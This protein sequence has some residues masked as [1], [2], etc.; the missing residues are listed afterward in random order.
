MII[1]NRS[2]VFWVVTAGLRKAIM[3]VT[4]TQSLSNQ[5]R[6][7]QLLTQAPFNGAVEAKRSTVS[8][9]AYDRLGALFP[10]V[11]LI[12]SEVIHAIKE[13]DPGCILRMEVRARWMFGLYDIPEGCF[14]LQ[15]N[16]LCR[17]F[18]CDNVR[19]TIS[20]IPRHTHNGVATNDYAKLIRKIKD[21]Y[22]EASIAVFS[23][24]LAP[25]ALFRCEHS[26]SSNYKFSVN[27]E[28]DHTSNNYKR[29]L[30]MVAGDPVLHYKTRFAQGDDVRWGRSDDVLV[31]FF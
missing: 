23:P 14:R 16:V 29:S 28:L 27:M 20:V 26:S 11:G 5:Q 9:D 2:L 24:N 25:L 8:H 31:A 18:L 6:I 10:D 3:S 4:C 12:L 13:V 19:D 22:P 30:E 17:C 21:S 7:I 1:G 15:K